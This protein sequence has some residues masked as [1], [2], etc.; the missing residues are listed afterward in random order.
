MHIHISVA[1][2]PP[3][4]QAVMMDLGHGM[5]ENPDAD[6]KEVIQ[7]L[8][9]CEQVVTGLTTRAAIYRK[10]QEILNGEFLDEEALE[11]M[12]AELGKKVRLWRGIDSFTE[13]LEE[14][15]LRDF[16]QATP[17][18][19]DEMEV[20]VLKYWRTVQLNERD[21]ATNPAVGKFR[22]MV[23]EVKLTIPVFADL[24]SGCLRERHW[25]AVESALGFDLRNATHVSFGEL[26]GHDLKAASDAISKAVT[27][28]EQEAVL[29]RLLNKVKEAWA[30]AEFT[31]IPHHQS[32][33][34]WLL[35]ATTEITAQLDD[36]LVTISNVLASPYVG[37]IREEV[38]ALESELSTFQR[39][40]DEW[41]NCQRLWVYL[42]SIL[43]VPDISRQLIAETKAFAPVDS[44]WKQFMRRVSEHPHCLDTGTTGG[45]FDTFAHHAATLE[46]IVHSIERF[47]E[48]K[49]KAFPRFYFLSDEELLLLLS[50][51]RDPQA[52]Q[53]HLGKCFDA[54]HALEFGD[55]NSIT[56]M[57]SKEGER[58][59]LGPN[60]KARG[61]LEDWMSSLE[62]NMRR[63]VSRCLML[64]ETC[65][66]LPEMP[67][68]YSSGGRAEW[69]LQSGKPAQVVATVCQ[70]CIGT[71]AHL[72]ITVACSRLNSP[73]SIGLPIDTALFST[74]YRGKLEPL[75]RLLLVAIVTGDV[76][77]RDVLD[78]L[79]DEAVTSVETFQWQV[80]LR[81]YWQ[82][83]RGGT[84][85]CQGTA[86]ISYGHEYQG[87]TSRLVVTPLTD[88]CWMTIT[89][90]L[91]L[92]LGANPLGPAGTGKSETTKDLAKGLGVQC[93]VF[94]CSDQI[95]HFMTGRLLS[96]LAQTGAWTCLD[97]FNRIDVE[98]LSVIAQQIIA[99][100]H[101]LLAGST[102]ITFEGQ[103]IPVKDHLVV[104][105]M[106]PG[107]AGRTELPNNLKVCFRPIAMM[108]PDYAMIA[109]II[110]FGEGFEGAKQLSAKITTLARL[111]SEQLS[112][113]PHYDFGMRAIKSVLVFAGKMKRDQPDTPDEDLLVQA[114]C[115][116]NLPKM[117]ESDLLQFA[118][119][120]GDLF[121]GKEL[122]APKLEELQESVLPSMSKDHLYQLIPEQPERVFQL[123][124]TLKVRF[125]VALVGEA[126]SGKTTLYQLLA[127]AKAWLREKE[128]AGEASAATCVS[129]P[130]TM[131]P[132]HHALLPRTA[133]SHAE[134]DID[135]GD[136]EA[137]ADED[138]PT[139]QH[140]EI[141]ISVLNP[142]SVSVGDLYGQ[143]NQFTQ[144]W[145]DGL[146]SDLIRNA[147]MAKDY[148]FREHWVVFDGPIDAVWIESMNT[149][150]DDS[151]M[152]CLASGERIKLQQNGVRLLFEVEGLQ[153]ASPATV[154]RLGVVYVSARP[155][156]WRHHV[157]SW[158][159]G[160]AFERAIAG[161]LPAAAIQLRARVNELVDTLLAPMIE[162]MEERGSSVFAEEVKTLPSQRIAS[163]FALLE[164]VLGQI[165]E[166]YK[167]TA[168]AASTAEG[169][170]LPS[171]C[172]ASATQKK[173]A[174]KAAA[175][176]ALACMFGSSSTSVLDQV[177]AFSLI[178]GLGGGL[179][180][181]PAI[182]FDI[183]LR[184]LVRSSGL[185][186]SIK[187]PAEDTVFDHYVHFNCP[188]VGA[189]PFE[190]RPWI[191]AVQPFTY[192]SATPVYEMMV[193]T[194]DTTR[195][196]YLLE[197]N[198]CNG[199]PT[200]LTGASGAGKT[201]LAHH[202]FKK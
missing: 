15:K 84:Y 80:Q 5:L 159:K 172:F 52:V 55:I 149:V 54:V 72:K 131:P 121:P 49:R 102:S 56:A 108:V 157:D 6:M 51:A 175:S 16:K 2:M 165:R 187:L 18:D 27:E 129:E 183:F 67:L 198:L 50:T 70:V 81:P 128:I 125:G 11:E 109:E 96:G 114:L 150:L 138:Q 110:L 29:M 4:V 173:A 192:T 53:P 93:I 195:F 115:N 37:Y 30:D 169:Y 141:T 186:N 64:D 12:E 91:D 193:P 104:V 78:A 145:R 43:T 20:E 137:L 36:S 179:T 42:E 14:W 197:S 123:N 136:V 94:N 200:Y 142:K 118:A 124:E 112:R 95:D 167:A 184:D 181:N 60:L 191:G 119:I 77:N 34:A 63:A 171:R 98:V 82:Q 85:V 154:S 22:N 155:L 201:M 105:T 46:G 74:L 58:L 25:H 140:K 7:H 113:Q 152:L 61:A 31:L 24:C 10:Q 161:A 134:K 103:S 153:Q 48:V 120:I 166:L 44:F 62:D 116:S 101:A 170:Q 92:K 106:N 59:M 32:S 178:W 202:I 23:E 83:E 68:Q 8:A 182:S 28:A 133:I 13:L 143:L 199:R 127:K 130:L 79:A 190:W 38:E 89:G 164:A 151:L 17:K 90:A 65:S 41:L 135:L 189:M 168:A 185:Y 117:V 196:G 71:D 139:T 1:S 3:L 162:Y 111:G 40:L 39:T 19:V 45:L 75:V 100:R 194:A 177:L 76:H 188:G 158:L 144:E 35:G 57:V 47:M 86:C 33:E 9:D 174:S 107:Y 156:G 176:K 148:H 122:P 21:L 97:E 160:N 180:G 99:L 26:M 88:R 126:A 69:I 132:A 147:A 146:A 87:A 73:F 66:G 163:M